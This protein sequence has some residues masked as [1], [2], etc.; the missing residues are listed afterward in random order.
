MGFGLV[1]EYSEVFQIIT[2]SSYS[3]VT[4][5]CT[6]QFTTA[7]TKSFQ[8]VVSSLVVAWQRLPAMQIPHLSF[9]AA[10]GL[11]GWWP[12]H[13]ELTQLSILN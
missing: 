1:F 13:N 7:H 4:N 12:L 11:A 2:T 10:S 5:L 3:T 6:L 9:S 8:S